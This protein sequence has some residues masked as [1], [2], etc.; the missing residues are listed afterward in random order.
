M[1]KKKCEECNGYKINEQAREIKIGR[2]HIGELAMM[3][4]DDLIL[5]LEN[6]T[7]QDIRSPQGKSIRK[8][9]LESLNRIGWLMLD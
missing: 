7:H 6:L 4:V 9:I 8:S 3:P 2:K 5:Y 1:T